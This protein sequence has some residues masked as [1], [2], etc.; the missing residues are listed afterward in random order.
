M[1]NTKKKRKEKRLVGLDKAGPS[2]YLSLN[3]EAKPYL[4]ASTLP[5]FSHGFPALIPLCWRQIHGKTQQNGMRQEEQEEGHLRGGL[6]LPPLFPLPYVLGKIKMSWI[7]TF[8]ALIRSLWW[9][10]A[11][12]LSGLVGRKVVWLFLFW[13]SDLQFL[14]LSLRAWFGQ[15]RDRIKTFGELENCIGLRYLLAG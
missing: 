12:G 2:P 1:C 15:P 5:T 8:P 9:C 4:H 7:C 3:F 13:V 14:Q 6:V 11:V 10:L